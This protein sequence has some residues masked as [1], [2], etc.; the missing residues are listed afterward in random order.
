MILFFYGPDTYR[1]RGH[2][3]QSIDQFKKQ[4]DPQGYNTVIFDAKNAEPGAMLSEL[5]AAP[6]LAEKRM[7]VLQNVL[8]VSDKEFLGTLIETIS[9]EKISATTVLV[10]WQGESL[11]KVKEAKELD[12]LLK[13]EKFAQEFTPLTGPALTSWITKEAVALKASFDPAGSAELARLTGHDMW[14][15]AS[16]LHQ[17]A[18]YANGRPITAVDVQLFAEEKLDDNVF[19]MIDAVVAGN[20]KTAFKLLQGQRDL[21]E[22]DGKLFGLFIWQ[23]RIILEI[24][25]LLAREPD[26]TSDTAAKIIGIHPFVAK[27]NFAI[28]KKHSLTKL[29]QLYRTLLDIDTKTKTGQADQSVLL[30]LFVAKV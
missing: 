15:L 24:A 27:K 16:T 8:S 17:L 29:K 28:A 2:L 5:R 6:F 11:S 1:S 23:F 12:T 25:D 14:F 10:L 26:T 7:V 13:K 22:E 9:A 21:G 18:A 19:N 3:Q 30:D 20:H 4:R